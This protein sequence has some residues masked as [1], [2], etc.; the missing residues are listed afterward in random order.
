VLF[1]DVLFGVFEIDGGATEALRSAAGELG[2]HLQAFTPRAMPPFVE[3]LVTAVGLE[4]CRLKQWQEISMK[5]LI[6]LITAN[7]VLGAAV[8]S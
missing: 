8:W 7:V 6:A 5:L 1:V 3:R 4:V 2:R